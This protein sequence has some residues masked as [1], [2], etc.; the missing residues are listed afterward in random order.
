[1]LCMMVGASRNVEQD[2][3]LA[4]LGVR[5]LWHHWLKRVVTFCNSLVQLPDT[6]MYSRILKDSCF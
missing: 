1:M 6:H 4:E 3:L 2:I 5:P